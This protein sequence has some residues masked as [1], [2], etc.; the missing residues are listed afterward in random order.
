MNSGLKKER[1]ASLI[2][3]NTIKSVPRKLSNISSTIVLSPIEVAKLLD[4]SPVKVLN[5][6]LNKLYGKDQKDSKEE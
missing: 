2:L 6:S 1:K 5:S 4:L 3:P